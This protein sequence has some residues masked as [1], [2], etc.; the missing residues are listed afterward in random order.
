MVDGVSLR[1]ARDGDLPLLYEICLR[2]ADAGD[3]AT[4]LYLHPA[5][6]GEIYVGP[7]V[8]LDE[9]IG[10]VAEDEEGPGGYIVAALDTLA[11]EA[12]AEA[13]WWPPLRERYSAPSPGASTP[14]EELMAIVHRPEVTEERIAARYPAHL[15]ISLLPRLQG[16]GV[17]R[18]LME[19]LFSEMEVA[20]VS[21]VHLGVETRNRRAIRFYT[22]LGFTMVEPDGDDGALMGL[23]LGGTRAPTS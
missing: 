1:T 17:G 18:M 2:T 3:D 4:D 9:G 7:Y 21:G 10:F 6:P 15:H 11:F 14:D 19:R 22:R 8:V 20:G 5:L 16:K 13:R 12:A 23:R